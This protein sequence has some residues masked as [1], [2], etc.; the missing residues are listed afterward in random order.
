MSH[1]DVCIVGAGPAGGIVASDLAARGHD[2]TVLEAG[3]R[4][5]ADDRLERMERALRPAF[6]RTDVWDMGGERDAYTTT[7][8]VRYALNQYRVK[9]VGGSTLDWPAT[10]PRLHPEDFEMRTRHGVATDWAVSYETLGAYYLAAERELGV[11]GAPRDQGPPRHDGF[12]L[13]AHPPSYVD[14]LLGEAFDAVGAPLERAPSAINSRPY[15]GRSECVGY[16]TC[17]PVCPSGAKYT[18]EVHVD[19]AASNGARIVTE[20]PVE[21][22]RHDPSGERIVEAVYRHEGQRK[23]LSADRFVLAAGGVETPRLLLLSA[24][25]QFPNGLANASGLVGRYFADHPLVALVGRLDEPTGTD[26]I[27]FDTSM[28]EAFYGHPQGPTGSMILQVANVSGHG[29]TSTGVQSGGYLARLADG[30]PL[31]PVRRDGVGDSLLEDV[32]AAYGGRVRI[33]AMVEPLPNADNRV[34][35]DR[36]T[37]DTYGNP[38]PEITFTV[39]DGTGDTLERARSVL[40]DVFEE[41][42]VYDVESVASPQDPHFVSHQMG[43]TRMGMDPET[44]VVTPS[45]RAHDLENLYIAGSSVFPTFGAAP[46]TL[47]IAALALRLANHLD[48]ILGDG[49]LPSRTVI[50]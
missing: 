44:S 34:A 48:R 43:T 26:Q 33:E 20:A 12:P 3:P 14:G 37:T 35:L 6:T 1:T 30:D 17:R 40:Y 4:F 16:G 49:R 28:S 19:R 21:Q 8:D 22:L 29:P 36:G 11:A 13:P 38:V 24:S 2:V 50:R 45:L 32:R 42:G 41:A 47:T 10:A 23:R 7:G 46:P 39:D 31:A 5:D 15:A 9:G 27:G 18:A 25:D